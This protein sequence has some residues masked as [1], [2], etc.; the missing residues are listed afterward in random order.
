MGYELDG[1]G[2]I[3]LFSIAPSQA[4]EPISSLLPNGYLGLSPGVKR[5]GR[6]A[7][8]LTPPSADV[9][10]DGAVPPLSHLSSCQG[11]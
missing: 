9:M 7:D 10:N 3:F 8:Y 4:L 1:R 11:V 5:Q 6:E 2:S